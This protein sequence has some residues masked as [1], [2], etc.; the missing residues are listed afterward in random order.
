MKKDILRY[1]EDNGI[2]EVYAIQGN[3]ITYYSYYGADGFY[4]ITKN[5]KTGKETRQK[6]RFK[7]APKYLKTKDGYTRYN[8]FTG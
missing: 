4:K 3:T 1:C 2:Y 7:K 6:L 8:Y 5:I